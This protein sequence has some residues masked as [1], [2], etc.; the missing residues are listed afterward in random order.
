MAIGR[1]LLSQRRKAV[2]PE[3]WLDRA[4][5]EDLIRPRLSPVPPVAQSVAQSVATEIARPVAV[6]DEPEAAGSGAP[7]PAQIGVPDLSSVTTI[8]LNIP[9]ANVQGRRASSKRVKRLTAAGIL[10]LAAAGGVAS[11]P[12]I[13][14][15]SGSRSPAVAGNPMPAPPVVAVPAPDA[16]N[17][18][19]PRSNEPTGAVVAAPAAAPN[20]LAEGSTLPGAPAASPPRTTRSENRSTGRSQPAASRMTPPPRGPAIPPEAYEWYQTAAGRAG[21]QRWT[22]LHPEPAP[23]P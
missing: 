11:V 4:E 13:T 20:K 22:P 19:S 1:P 23:S 10:A 5:F 14:S 12:L 18:D 3:L 6:D 9:L 21:D 16:G 2:Q 7:E 15:H 17:N 8:P